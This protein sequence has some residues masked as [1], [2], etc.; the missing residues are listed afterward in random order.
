[1]RRQ[2][3]TILAVAMTMVPVAPSG[4]QSSAAPDWIA[5]ARRIVERMALERGERVLLVGVP[6]TADGL[7]A[8]LREA[9]VRVGGV[10]LGA[11]ASGAG[12]PEAWATDFTR[13]AAGKSV[14][15]LVSYLGT[16]AVAVM[17][18]GAT[19]ADPAYAAMQRVIAPP[20][21]GGAR[22]I[23]FHW[24]GAYAMSGELLQP[25]LEH[26]LVYQRALLA[27]D[28][29]RLAET[30]LE[31]ERAMR[32]KVV[33]VTTPAGTDLRFSI[34]DRPVSRQDGDA[35]ATRARQGRTLIDR[36]IELPAGAIRVA[37]IEESVQGKIAFPDGEWGG[38]K[39]S[40]LVMR[41]VDGRLDSFD[42]TAG[43]AGVEG[44]LAAAG[45]AGKSFREFVLGLNP[46]LAIPSNGER[47][48][49]YY[50]YG[51]GVVRLSLGDNS[52][53]GGKVTGGWV[54]WNFFTDA[55]V[56]IGEVVRVRDGKLV[57]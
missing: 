13:G 21:A 56:R 26:G 44:E 4:A 48:I 27:T 57:R 36:E 40:G 14:D 54:R 53:L 15:E 45:E 30:Q 46:L 6:G 3:A 52:E 34:G 23:H 47:W 8:P 9:V 19:P 17:L 28:Y 33:R 35:S 39:V 49:P 2:V 24:T 41:F 7:V 11:L 5:I 31:I 1:M 42:A 10:D 29:A 22:T 32:G 18:P 50:G 51:A 55:T 16:V 43:R 20:S 25:T 37:P 12:T 38:M